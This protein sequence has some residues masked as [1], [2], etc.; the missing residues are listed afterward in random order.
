MSHDTSLPYAE[1]DVGQVPAAG[2]TQRTVEDGRAIVVSGV[3]PRCS[4]P[5]VTRRPYGAPGTGTKGGWPFRRL[6][7]PA[8][9]DVVGSELHLCECGHP[10]PGLPADAVFVGCGASWRAGA[11]AGGTP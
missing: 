5:T 8:A 1:L 6:T 2:F 9:P 4:G 10:H 11:A 7:G 3:C